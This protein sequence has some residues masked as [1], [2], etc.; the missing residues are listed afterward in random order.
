MVF[1][2]I[3]FFLLKMSALFYSSKITALV[4][5]LKLHLADLLAKKKKWLQ[6]I[7]GSESGQLASEK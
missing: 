3:F 2:Y 7:H 6:F 4:Q 5:Q 1:I